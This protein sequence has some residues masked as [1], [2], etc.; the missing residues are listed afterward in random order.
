MDHI[1]NLHKK[2]YWE[3]ADPDKVVLE[4]HNIEQEY[5]IENHQGQSKVSYV[6]F[7]MAC[8]IC[9]SN[10]VIVNRQNFLQVGIVT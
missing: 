3:Y 9:I 1:T 5:T 10:D 7:E 6:V 2:H 8:E 4:E